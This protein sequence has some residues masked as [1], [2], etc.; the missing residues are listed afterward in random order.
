MHLD[1]R[2]HLEILGGL[3]EIDREG[4]LDQRE[5]H[6]NGVG[7]VYPRLRDLPDVDHE[8]L[9]EERDV[10]RAADAGDLP[11]PGKSAEVAGFMPFLPEPLVAFFVF[12]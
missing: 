7:A 9:A 1:D 6:E 3:D 12:F 2:L 10:D 4:V 8:V 5:Q 11:K